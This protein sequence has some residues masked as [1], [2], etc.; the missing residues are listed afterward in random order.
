MK[1]SIRELLIV[2]TLGA[3]ASGVQAADLDKVQRDAEYKVTVAQ[4]R[5]DFKIGERRLQDPPGQ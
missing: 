4:C 1:F 5:C 2:T 3:F